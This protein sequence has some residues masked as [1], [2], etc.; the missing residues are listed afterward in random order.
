MDTTRAV[1]GNALAFAALAPAARCELYGARAQAKIDQVK[2][3]IRRCKISGL[4]SGT[5]RSLA[6]LFRD[7]RNDRGSPTA[8]RYKIRRKIFRRSGGELGHRPLEDDQ[9]RA[10]KL[11]R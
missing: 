4:F 8:G 7:R 11:N 1:T 10:A 2:A 5:P 3:D 9:L 6:R